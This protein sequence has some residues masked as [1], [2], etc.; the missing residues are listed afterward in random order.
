[1]PV[2]NPFAP[3]IEVGGQAQVGPA[4][5]SLGGSLGLGNTAVADH[6]A[7]AA[8]LLVAGAVLI[9]LHAKGKFRF[10]TTVG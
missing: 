8:L 1:M 4:S 7:A 5:G 10:S 6:H 9:F 2:S 3:T